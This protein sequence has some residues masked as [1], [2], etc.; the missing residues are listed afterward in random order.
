K[1]EGK[2]LDGEIALGLARLHLAQGKDREAEQEIDRA[3]D[4]VAWKRRWMEEEIKV[5]DARLAMR[6]GD[7]NRAFRLLHGGIFSGNGVD[8]TEGQLLLAIAAQATGRKEELA[9]A[10]KALKDSGAEMGLLAVK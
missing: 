6:R 7:L 4:A 3:R 1:R 2:M 8:S 9:D 5:L 10:L